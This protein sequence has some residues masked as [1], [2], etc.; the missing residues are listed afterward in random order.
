MDTQLEQRKIDHLSLCSNE[1][2]NFRTTTTLFENVRLIHNALPEL[3][4]DEIDLSCTV[5]GKQLRAPLLIASM[6]GGTEEAS[7]INKTL[8]S[9]AEERNYAFGLGSQRA[10][11]INEEAKATYWIRDVAPTTLAFGNIGLIQARDISTPTLEK[12]VKETAVDA[13]CVHLNPAMELIQS[14]G[15]R[16]FRGGLSTLQRLCA[17]FPVPIILKETGCGISS[18]VATR[19][20]EVGVQHLDISGAGGTSWVGVETK[21]AQKKADLTQ[22][23]LGEALWDWGIPTA[24]N[25]LILAPLKFKTLIATGGIF[26][27]VNATKAIVLGANLVGIARPILKALHAGGREQVIAFLDNVEAQMRALMMLTG[28]R[29]LT[30]LQKTRFIVGNELHLWREQSH[31]II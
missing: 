17:S 24:A 10:M 4:M 1:E 15:D 2:V 26:D 14:H 20:K 16:D 3:H 6:T 18:E 12:L 31:R 27:G 11:L 22:S 21:R 7:H 13:L 5:F 30:Q 8:A 29:N 28:S 9:I 23:L 25:V 19:A